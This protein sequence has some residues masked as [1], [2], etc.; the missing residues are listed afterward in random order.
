M[1][2]NQTCKKTWYI[3]T[4][5][6]ITIWLKTRFNCIHSSNLLTRNFS[7]SRTIP[8]W[9]GHVCPVVRVIIQKICRSVMDSMLRDAL[10]NK[11]NANVQI[12]KLQ[13]SLDLKN[14]RSSYLFMELVVLIWS[15]RS[16]KMRCFTFLFFQSAS[17]QTAACIAFVLNANIFTCTFLVGVDAM[18]QTLVDKR[19]RARWLCGH[20]S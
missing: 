13:G 11:W 15:G 12:N 20:F 7:K 16:G 2:P 9:L 17:G 5:L 18:L 10:K 3:S 8:S 14:T 1:I 6:N 4:Y 19:K